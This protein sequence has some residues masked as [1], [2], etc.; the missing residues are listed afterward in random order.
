MIEKI[1]SVSN[2]SVLKCTG[3]SW[4]QWVKILDSHGA[5]AL[6]HQDIVAFIRKNYKL[7]PWWEQQVTSS[8]EIHIGRRAPGQNLNGQYTTT[9]TKTFSMTQ[10]KLWKFL[11]SK[12]GM[13]QW[14]KPFSDFKIK[15]GASF[16]V[17]GGVFGEVRTIKAGRGFRMTWQEEEWPK[18]STVTFHLVSRPKSK[19]M[20]VI[21]HEG[22]REAKVKVKMHAHWREMIDNLR[23]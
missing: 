15:P 18:A 10:A 20:L 5:R 12:A 6:S 2:K 8:Y 23:V 16:E 11:N 19:C 22:I 17:Y 13:S 21:S 7:G 4:D 3:K 14:L 1:A 9:V